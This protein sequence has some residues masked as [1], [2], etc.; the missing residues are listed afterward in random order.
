MVTIKDVAKKAGVSISTVSRVINNSK[1]V[2]NEIRQRVL[3]VIKETG[4]VP[5]PLARSL[6][7]KKSQLI[8]VIVPDISDF[9][10]GELLNGIEEVGKI[11]DYDILL[12]NSYGEPDE[13]LKY[14]NLLKSKQ[15]AGIIFVS[16][17]MEKRHVEAIESGNIPAVYISKNAKDFDIYS[18]SIDNFKASYEMTKYL[19]ENGHKK[20]AF[21]KSS[22]QDSIMDSDR[23]KGYKK[24]L[25]ENNIKL[26]ETLIKEG[27]S[28]SE[29][30]HYLMNEIFEFK[31]IP[32]AVFAANDEVAVGVINCI[33]D[34]G[35]KVPEDISV[36]GFNDIKLAS[37]YRPSLTTIKQP[38]YDMGAVSIRMIVKM[39]NE[40]EIGD[41]NIYLPYKLIERQSVS[42]K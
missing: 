39:I 25:E 1:P 15:V 42:K 17:K 8:G 30:G 29:S 5:N 41:K 36:A 16:W 33:L 32:D 3:K 27:D 10:M 20:I 2:S 19:I 6:V 13:E 24:A 9:F 18:V 35:Y 7:T 40:E 14:I 38:I 23:F 37:L 11:Y 22:V 34:N 21:I 31:N 12:C 4:Y 26:E 28:T